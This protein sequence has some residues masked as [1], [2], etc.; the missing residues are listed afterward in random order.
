MTGIL[1]RHAFGDIIKDFVDVDF[2]EFHD[3][4]SAFF[5]ERTKKKKN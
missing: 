4:S 1:D 3:E 5:F 2:A